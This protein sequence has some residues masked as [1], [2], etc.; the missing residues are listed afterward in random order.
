MLSFFVY[1]WLAWIAFYFSI[2]FSNFNFCFVVK[3]STFK[4]PEKVFPSTK[5]VKK[6]KKINP[7]HWVNSGD[8]WNFLF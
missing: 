6:L 1:F 7:T 8:S 2:K 3:K 4:F 5:Y